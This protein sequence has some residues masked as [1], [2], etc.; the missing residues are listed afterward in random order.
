MGDA[1]KLR[2]QAARYRRMLQVTDDARVKAVLATMLRECEDEA[3][4]IE[5][6]SGDQRRRNEGGRDV[7]EHQ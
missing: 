3:Q 2:E 4:R 6:G 1:I 5:S 7:P